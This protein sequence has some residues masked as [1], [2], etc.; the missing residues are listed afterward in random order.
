MCLKK[1]CNPRS[2]YRM[3]PP[4]VGFP[5]QPA[6][7]KPS[8]GKK[9][10]E[11]HGELVPKNW[12]KYQESWKKLGF[13]TQYLKLCWN[14]QWEIT[15]SV[16]I[17]RKRIFLAPEIFETGWQLHSL[18]WIKWDVIQ[19]EINQGLELPN[20]SHSWQCQWFWE[21]SLF[22]KRPYFMLARFGGFL[23]LFFVSFI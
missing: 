22:P 2:K 5:L 14:A 15:N 9:G 23:D 10:R 13:Q 11:I 6:W 21:M 3:G 16:L 7:N 1:L 4:W 19:P 12:K 8:T 20:C 17:C 18:G